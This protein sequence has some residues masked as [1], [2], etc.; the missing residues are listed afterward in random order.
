MGKHTRRQY[1]KAGAFGVAG[2]TGLY[3]VGAGGFGGGP[4]TPDCETTPPADLDA[5][6][7]GQSSSGPTVVE[8]SDFS[9]PHCREFALNVMPTLR[10]QYLQS[11]KI[12]YRHY[13]FPIPVDDWSRPAASAAREVQRRSGDTAFA[14]YATALYRH[15]DD[16]SDDLFASLAEDINIAPDPVRKAAR[17]QAYCRTINENIQKGQQKGVEGTPTI[18]VN[19]K[20]LEAPNT[21]Q[22]TDAIDQHR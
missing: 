17:D 14:R 5:P 4:S 7:L 13:D 20:K 19:E 8:F 18:F 10:Q 15:Q 6:T 21:K 2:A 1:L 3:I 22:L 12:T 11:R 16:F 9:C